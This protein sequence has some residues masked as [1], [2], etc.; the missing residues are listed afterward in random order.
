MHK[1]ITLALLLI[2]GVNVLA[3]EPPSAEM[4]AG[5]AACHGAE[6]EGKQ[7]LGAPPLAGQDAAYLARQLNNFKAGRRGYAE[8]DLAGRH[9]RSFASGLGEQGIASLSAH[10]AGLPAVRLSVAAGAAEPNGKALYADTCA[11][12][13]GQ[14]AEGSPQMQAPN[15]RILGGWYIDQQL[16]GYVQGWRGAEAHSDIQGMWMRSIATHVSPAQQPALVAYIE[17]LGAAS[18]KAGEH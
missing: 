16:A 8:Q 15:L 3:A 13:H 10:F 6:G 9:M 7:A 1:I 12:C 18:G 17:S 2:A 5:C 4:L 14:Q 11:Q